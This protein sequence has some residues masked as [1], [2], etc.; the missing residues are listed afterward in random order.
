[1]LAFSWVIP[2]FLF[3]RTFLNFPPFSCLPAQGLRLTS[4]INLDSWLLP[5]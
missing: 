3:L 4:K 5:G 2:P 1:M